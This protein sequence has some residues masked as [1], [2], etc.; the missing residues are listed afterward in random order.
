MVSGGPLIPKFNKLTCSLCP[1]VMTKK[2][3]SET[4]SAD[5]V[6]DCYPPYAGDPCSVCGWDSFAPP[7]CAVEMSNKIVV[8]TEL[9]DGMGPKGEAIYCKK[10]GTRKELLVAIRT[11]G[12]L[13]NYHMWVNQWTHHQIK[14]TRETFDAKTEIS[15]TVDWA[16]RYKMLAHDNPKC[17][18]G[19]T[20]NQ[21]VALVLHSPGPRPAEG[22]ARPVVCDVWRIWSQAK[23]NAD[24]GFGIKRR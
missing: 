19:T 2:R 10:S 6:P 4:S 15:V 16:A 11:E 7:N 18:Y 21:Y 8:W 20:C 5:G 23:G 22:G 13:Y 3:K 1:K 9:Q 17:S 24:W 14:L 12:P